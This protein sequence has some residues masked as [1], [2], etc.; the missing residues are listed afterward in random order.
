MLGRGRRLQSK[1]LLSF[2]NLLRL[3]T[4]FA[5]PDLLIETIDGSYP[6]TDDFIYTKILH[7][8]LNG[9]PPVRIVKKDKFKIVT[10]GRYSPEKQID[11]VVSKFLNDFEPNGCHLTVFG[12]TE[13]QFSNHFPEIWFENINFMGFS[14]EKEIYSEL[15]SATY[16]ISGNALGYLGNAELE[17]LAHNCQ[18][19]YVQ[20][21]IKSH[22]PEI[23][24]K[25][26][27]HPIEDIASEIG[28]FDKIHQED[29]TK[30]MR[31]IHSH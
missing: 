9:V 15:E 27:Q 7:R 24:W 16:F 18:I 26:L 25:H 17:A 28:E 11:K 10:T 6:L 23:I 2:R 22:L 4:K 13:E 3:I 21:P 14:T 31:V 29:V 12:C 19:V 8:R 5:K 1:R 20:Q 30:I